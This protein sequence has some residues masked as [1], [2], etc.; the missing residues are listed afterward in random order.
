MEIIKN[1][2]NNVPVTILKTNKFKSVTGKLY[3][4]SL[5]NKEKV[6]YRDV[7]RSILLESCKKY[8]TPE[9]LYI[10]ALENYD[11]Y[12]ST[13]SARYGN[14]QISSF[15]FLSLID[16]YTKEGNLDEVADTFC[17]FIF[18]PL[19]K[20]NAFDKETF[21]MIV[22]KKKAYLEKIKESSEAYAER[23][24]YKSL[25]QNKPYSYMSEIKYLDEMTP[26]SL[27]K[28]YLSMINESEVELVLAG[29]I[30]FDNPIIEKITSRIKNNKTFDNK[31]IITNDDEKDELIKIKDKASGTQNILN[32]IMYLKNVNDYEINYVAPLYIIILGGSG[33]FSRIFRIIREENSLA[34]YSFGTFEKDDGIM[35]ITMGIEK[36]NYDKAFDL[37]CEVID[38]MKKINEKELE[39]AKKSL[40]SSLLESLDNIFNVTGR[41]YNT[42]L[43]NLPQVD[44]F[45]EKINKVKVDDIELLATKLKPN[46]SYFL[47]GEKTNG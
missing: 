28:D 44:E 23:M 3:F 20:N 17:E 30:E 42:K 29:D 13:S 27:Y 45:I 9:R 12:Y 37:T 21:D 39:E 19:V 18:N 8:N 15:T 4:K 38:S 31:L 6:T 10:K 47:E 35:E 43:F 16:K 2:V 26:E 25:N 7:L 40:T 41:Y 46:L 24:T 14:Y 22:S 34:Y 1:T 32:I 33:S 5:V 11:A 36:E